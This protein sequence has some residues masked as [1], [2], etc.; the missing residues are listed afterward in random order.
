MGLCATVLAVDPGRCK[1]GVAVVRNSDNIEVLHRAVVSTEQIS[2][3]LID[4][5]ARYSPEAILIGNG[6]TASFVKEMADRLDRLV[7]LVDERLTS[8]EARKRYFRENPPKGLRKF[9][10][11]SLQTPN[12]PIDDYVAVILAERYLVDNVPAP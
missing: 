7:E 1:C 10:P 12:V 3:I 8:V 5:C 2:D 6:T 4:L 11:T 9:I